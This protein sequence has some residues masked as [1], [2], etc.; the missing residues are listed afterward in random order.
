MK[1][2]AVLSDLGGVVVEFDTD[3]VVHYI[4][5]AAGRSF[6]D[7]QQAVY[8]K[9]RLLP[10]ELGQIQPEAYYEGLRSQL[11]LSWSYDQFVRFWNDI[12]TENRPVSR[13]L[14]K[15][16]SRMRLFALSNTNVLHLD[17]IKNRILSPSLFHEWIASCDVGLRKPDPRIYRLDGIHRRPARDGRS[18]TRRR[19][20]G[21]S[22]RKSPTTGA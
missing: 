12:F 3:R 13:L 14:Q 10:F 2:T 7:V 5:Q 21:Y 11:R 6:D 9:E 18:R 19:P 4:A 16:R 20:A 15:L 22:V 1:Q 17:H 8:H